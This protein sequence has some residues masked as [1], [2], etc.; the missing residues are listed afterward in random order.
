MFAVA[1]DTSNELAQALLAHYSFDL[2]GYSP[3]E[4]IARWQNQYPLSWLHLAII[5]ALYQGR[6]KAISVQQILALW[7]RR[8]QVT[9][10]FNVEFE[11]LVCSRFPEIFT[12][13]PTISKRS[14]PKKNSHLR[15]QTYLSPVS[16]AQNNPESLN[17]TDT[18]IN[19]GKEHQS[20]E[21]TEEIP[22]FLHLARRHRQPTLENPDNID[23]SHNN[24]TYTEANYHWVD[25]QNSNSPEKSLLSSAIHQSAL[26]TSNTLE[27]SH[28][29]SSIA[30]LLAKQQLSHL[31]I[32]QINHPPI[33]QFIPEKSDR[34]NI[35][36]SKLKAISTHRAIDGEN[37]E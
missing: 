15:Q 24:S 35:F 34:S 20:P 12:V 10:H 3:S 7:Q 25:K 9:F 22:N 33:D 1:L 17:T 16:A 13:Q 31:E 23:T 30:T 32:C 4:L 36:T 2:G 5:E 6:Y 18:S 21:Q 27:N 19:T 29:D 28:D 26:E 8:E 37:Y 11:N 14:K